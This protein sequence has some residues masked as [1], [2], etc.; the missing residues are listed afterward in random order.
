[1]TVYTVRRLASL[2]GISVRTLHH[3]DHIGLLKPSDRTAAGYRLYAEEDLL[4]LQ[5]VL[6]FKELDMP[7]AEIRDILDSPG[8]DRVEALD[9]HRQL[10]QQRMV[11]LNRL[12][13]TID[14]TINKL[15]EDTMTLT[16]EELYEGFSREQIERYKREAQERY[17]PELV[18]ESQRRVSEMS[19]DQWKATQQ[20]SEDVARALAD[21]A[22]QD[23]AAP[24]VQAL[25]VRHHAWIE[26]FYP[27]SADVYR[28]LGMLYVQN[29]EFRAFYDKYRPGLADF[30][31]AAMTV[32][33]DAVLEEMAE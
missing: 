5:Q 13:N 20:E 33:A 7:L 23:P 6:F 2:A 27:C 16:D 3:Y 14:K 31:Q 26:V 25:I 4:R 15:T 1:M 8:F 9:H 30:M 24:E 19:R 12:L 28:G 32:Y 10:L 11:R 22:D 17:D 29:E 21:L 18:Q